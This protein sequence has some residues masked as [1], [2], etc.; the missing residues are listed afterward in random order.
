[1]KDLCTMEALGCRRVDYD[2]ASIP[3]YSHSYQDRVRDMFLNGWVKPSLPPEFLP[4]APASRGIQAAVEEIQATLKQTLKVGWVG[5]FNKQ[6]K[7]KL[8]IEVDLLCLLQDGLATAYVL[9]SPPGSE[10]YVVD[11]HPA[12]KFPPSKEWKFTVNEKSHDY[13]GTWAIP[14][15]Y[16]SNFLRFNP[17][18]TDTS[19]DDPWDR[20]CGVFDHSNGREDTVHN[21]LY[22]LLPPAVQDELFLNCHGPPQYD[23]PK[24]RNNLPPVPAVC[25]ADA[26]GSSADAAQP[27]AS[28]HTFSRPVLRAR[29]SDGHSESDDACRTDQV[30]ARS[31]SAPLRQGFAPDINR[32]GG[33]GAS[34]E[35]GALDSDWATI[36]KAFVNDAEITSPLLLPVKGRPLNTDDVC[37]IQNAGHRNFLIVTQNRKDGTICLKKRPWHNKWEELRRCLYLPAEPAFDARDSFKL[38]AD[39]GVCFLDRCPDLL[40]DR[41][42]ADKPGP[43]WWWKDTHAASTANSSSAP[44]GEFDLQR[45]EFLG[46]AFLDFCVGMDCLHL[47]CKWRQDCT[48]ADHEVSSILRE[49]TRGIGTAVSELTRNTSLRRLF[50]CLDLDRYLSPDPLP[51]EREKLPAD[52]VEALIG[53]AVLCYGPEEAHKIIR[54]WFQQ[55]AES[56]K[57]DTNGKD[58]VDQHEA[59]HWNI[60]SSRYLAKADWY[61]APLIRSSRGP[62]GADFYPFL[63]YESMD[64]LGSCAKEQAPRGKPQNSNAAVLSEISRVVFP[65]DK[66]PKPHDS[67]FSATHF[68]MG[69]DA[70]YSYRV[71]LHGGD[72]HNQILWLRSHDLRPFV[73]E[74]LTNM[75][76][77]AIDFDGVKITFLLQR[78]LSVVRLIHHSLRGLLP[79]ENTYSVMA[80]ASRTG[81]NSKDSCHLHFPLVVLPIDKCVDLAERLMTE[82]AAVALHVHPPRRFPHQSVCWIRFPREC[83]LPAMSSVSS[84]CAAAPCRRLDCNNTTMCGSSSY[85]KQH[86]LDCRCWAPCFVELSV[87]SCTDM[88]DKTRFEALVGQEQQGPQDDPQQLLYN[89]YGITSLDDVLQFCQELYIAAEESMHDACACGGPC[90]QGCFRNKF[91]KCMI[92]M[93]Q[94]WNDPQRPWRHHL[95]HLCRPCTDEHCQLCPVDLQASALTLPHLPLHDCIQDGHL[96]VFLLEGY[97]GY[98]VKHPVVSCPGPV[99]EDEQIVEDHQKLHGLYASPWGVDPQ[100]PEANRPDILHWGWWHASV[101]GRQQFPKLLHILNPGCCVCPSFPKQSPARLS[102]SHAL[103]LRTLPLYP[104]P[105]NDQERKERPNRGFFRLMVVDASRDDAVPFSPEELDKSTPRIHT[106]VDE[107]RKQFADHVPVWKSGQHSSEQDPHAL[108]EWVLGPISQFKKPS[109]MRKRLGN[110]V[111]HYRQYCLEKDSRS[112]EFWQKKLDTDIYLNRKL[113]MG[114]NDKIDRKS[115]SWE[116]ENRPLRYQ[117]LRTAD[118]DVVADLAEMPDYPF[119]EC[120]T[121]RSMYLLLHSYMQFNCL[122][123][124]STVRSVQLFYLPG[125]KRTRSPILHV[126]GECTCTEFG[127]A[128]TKDGCHSWHPRAFK[129]GD[130]VA[131]TLGSSPSQGTKKVGRTWFQKED[132]GGVGDSDDEHFRESQSGMSSMGSAKK[133]LSVKKAPSNVFCD[134]FRFEE[135]P[136]DQIDWNT[137]LKQRFKRCVHPVYTVETTGHKNVISRQE[138]LDLLGICGKNDSQDKMG[139]ESVGSLVEIQV[140]G[141]PISYGVSTESRLT[142]ARE[143]AFLCALAVKCPSK[144]TD[145]SILEWYKSE[146]PDGMDTTTTDISS[147][148]SNSISPSIAG[149]DSFLSTE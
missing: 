22:S 87:V 7:K 76:Q 144:L 114:L 40:Q 8:W 104:F 9:E 109:N 137:H 119:L 134:I 98:I 131:H 143:L 39:F 64:H 97:R 41:A 61:A 32:I 103:I 20:D 91:G 127:A 46:D 66:F 126:D 47:A 113:R 60:Y 1:M 123:G 80:D 30:T 24:D 89:H 4:P 146:Y 37:C 67:V 133:N 84:G 122:T 19:L 13:R 48:G 55:L 11:I 77:L 23:R 45:L 25:A 53:A 112:F 142:S 139:T 96:L 138:D 12:S 136:I 42:F 43:H 58:I 65:R 63:V 59:C 68:N 147:T 62:R 105:V 120:T 28:I 17:Q 49:E 141:Q 116:V 85:C 3:L 69:T 50:R 56:D 99:G 71:A 93:K 107:I 26:A 27:P 118:G 130:K 72:V 44:G 82:V 100:D 124:A 145:D 121:L 38:N 74:Q 92:G 33:V 101:Q 94:L 51:P 5:Y 148:S 52:V 54:I 115:Q 73:N 70:T 140:E 29:S 15:K 57:K 18:D 90:S 125:T 14:T 95:P 75:V 111:A 149:R 102:K 2:C 78:G 21:T 79:G 88:V 34:Q 135:M 117:G 35:H 110:L 31:Q 129:L 36:I 128:N 6:V 106:D 132:A 108:F 86:Y 81:P 16:Y 10:L 83:D